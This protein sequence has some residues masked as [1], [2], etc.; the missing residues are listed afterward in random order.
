MNLSLMGGHIASNTAIQ[1]WWDILH[2]HFKMLSYVCSFLI[3]P[4]GARIS[5]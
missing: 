3:K 2:Q 1:P 5:F 4:F